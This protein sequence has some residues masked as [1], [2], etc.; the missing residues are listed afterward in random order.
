MG[1]VAAPL[2][3]VSWDTG[4]ALGLNAFIAAALARFT[5]PYIAVAAGLGL[6]VVEAVAAG[7][8]SSAYRELFVYGTLLAYL[9][10]RD[11]AGSDGVVARVRHRYRYRANG[12][13]GASAPEATVS[14]RRSPSNGRHSVLTSVRTWVPAMSASAVLSLLVLA[15]PLVR[16][17]G[18]PESRRRVRPPRHRSH[19]P[20]ARDGPGRTFSLGQGAFY[21]VGGY[22]PPSLLLLIT[23]RPAPVSSPVLWSPP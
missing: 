20:R 19:R 7:Y 2:V 17:R 6:G 21:L 4:I 18:R 14:R 12:V 11:V 15:V 23:G 22:R 10:V 3:L 16:R 5:R 9:L 1:A 8:F 13:V